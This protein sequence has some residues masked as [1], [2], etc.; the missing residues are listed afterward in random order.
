MRK[1]KKEKPTHSHLTLCKKKFW[2]LQEEAALM[3]AEAEERCRQAAE[4]EEE[5]EAKPETSVRPQPKITPE[6]VRK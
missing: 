4:K 3:R 5:E 2:L 6:K 1:Y